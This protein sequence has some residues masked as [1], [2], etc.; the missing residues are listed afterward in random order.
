MGYDLKDKL[1]IGISSTALFDL[2]EEDTIFKSE[3]LDAYCK[4]QIS[5][6]DTPLR[7][8]TAFK[9]ICDILKIND[10]LKAKME[11]KRKAYSKISLVEVILM[12]KNSPD[13]SLRIFKSLETHELELI[14]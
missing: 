13:T 11:E 4:R 5:M 12:S 6:E 9:L 14:R 7:Q 8:G 10:L 2:T 3:G 1:V